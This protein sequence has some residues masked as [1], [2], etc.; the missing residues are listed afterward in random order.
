MSLLCPHPGLAFHFFF[1]SESG[2]RNNGL[3]YQDFDKFWIIILTA[4]EAYYQ[5]RLSWEVGEASWGSGRPS[6][7]GSGILDSH[8]GRVG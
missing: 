4:T 6:I 8:L 2:T 1:V 7:S 3:N 5:N